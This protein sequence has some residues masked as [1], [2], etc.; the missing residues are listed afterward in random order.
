MTKKEIEDYSRQTGVP[1][2]EIN[3][4]L[5]RFDKGG[6][7]LVDDRAYD[8][9][10]NGKPYIGYDDNRSLGKD[11]TGSKA[12]LPIFVNIMK[13]ALKNKTSIPFR[14]PDSIE[15][16][17]IDRTT[18][19]KPTLISKQSDIIFESFKR[20]TYMRKNEEDNIESLTQDDESNEELKEDSDDDVTRLIDGVF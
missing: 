4:N 12:A 9:Y 3:E 15:L 10:I 16:V 18:G 5:D 11:E 1:E 13:N 19:E 8:S 7:F 2:N 6:S 20:G 17:K 14:I